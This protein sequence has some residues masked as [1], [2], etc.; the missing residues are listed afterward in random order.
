VVSD[1]AT[2][3]DV[4]DRIN[5]IQER[6][7]EL[8]EEHRK[9]ADEFAAAEAAYERAFL[10]AHVRSLEDHT[11]RK[12]GAHETYARHAALDEYERRESA[13]ANELVV[14]HAQHSLRQ[15]LSAYQ[16]LGKFVADEAGHN[17]YGR[18]R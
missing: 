8:I 6:L 13:K 2:L 10:T 16:T 17:R 1:A 5:A 9:A 3:H 4:V 7:E 18:S 14:R 15:V 12:V 11:E